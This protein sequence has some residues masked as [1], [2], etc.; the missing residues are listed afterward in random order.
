VRLGDVATVSAEP[1][2][3]EIERDDQREMVPITA[4]LSGR[5]LGSAMREIQAKIKKN[6]PLAPGMSVEYGGLWKEQRSSF[7][8]LAV[9]LIAAIASVL[10]LLLISFRSWW[11]AGSVIVVAVASL[12]GVFAGLLVTGVAFNVTSFVGA[13]MMVGIVGENAYF[14]VMEY[15]RES[16][17]GKTPEEAAE[18]AAR[19]RARPVIMT[20]AAAVAALLPLALGIGSGSALLRPL[21]IAVIG[22]FMVSAFLLLLVLPSLLARMRPPAEA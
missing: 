4:R 11:E 6:L 19:R 9:V 18:G 7:Q 1:G 22:G 10:L 15:R 13:V 20:T 17:E 8:G 5:D 16:A 3:T 2:E 21:A 14:L 12:M